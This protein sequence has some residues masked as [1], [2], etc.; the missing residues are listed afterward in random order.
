MTCVWV[1]L[2]SCVENDVRWGSLELEM[3]QS[4]SEKGFLVKCESEGIFSGEV[5]G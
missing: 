1:K 5:G 3:G 4:E 2:A